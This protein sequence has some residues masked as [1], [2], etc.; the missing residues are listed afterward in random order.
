MAKTG[1]QRYRRAAP[2]AISEQQN[3]YHIAE[4]RTFITQLGYMPD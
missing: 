4:F 2:L 1:T 3:Q